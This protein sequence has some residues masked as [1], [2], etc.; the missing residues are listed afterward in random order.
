MMNTYRVKVRCSGSQ[1]F[2]IQAET[3]DEA[4]FYYREGVMVYDDLEDTE[5]IHVSQIDG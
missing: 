4:Q 2:E 5:I 1:T 3:A